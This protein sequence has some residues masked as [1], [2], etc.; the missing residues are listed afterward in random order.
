MKTRVKVFLVALL[1]GMTWLW[2]K[3]PP[4]MGPEYH[5][6]AGTY[7]QFNVSVTQNNYAVYNSE[8]FDGKLPKN[9]VIAL[10]NDSTKIGMTRF[11]N[12]HLIIRFNPRYNMTDAQSSETLLHE[13]CHIATPKDLDHGI[14]WEACMENLA[15]N[16][17]F[18]DV[19]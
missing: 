17:A 4:K 18:R 6:T 13:M 9:T 8:W 16:G 11:E 14:G 10:T 1:I 12:G 5:R 3:M 7:P 2:A 19:W 15:L